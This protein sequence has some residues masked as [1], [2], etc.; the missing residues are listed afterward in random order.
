MTEPKANEVW[1]T[2]EGHKV[3]I[4]WSFAPGNPASQPDDMHLCMLWFDEV[5]K[6]FTV[7]ELMNR[8]VCRQKMTATEWF[9]WAAQQTKGK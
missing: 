6:T 2:R 7:S 1:Q 9:Y 8:L 4:V 3:L 5:D